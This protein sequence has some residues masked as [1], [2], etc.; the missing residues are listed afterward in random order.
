MTSEPG[1]R[2]PVALRYTLIQLPEAAL[3]AVLL[4][5]AVA[6]GWL[7]PRWVWIALAL[8]LVKDVALYPLYRHAL[9][10][11]PPHGVAALLGERA[12]VATRLCPHGQ[13]RLRGERWRA[14]S[15]DGQPLDPGTEVV[16]V[17]HRGLTLVVAPAAANR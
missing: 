3:V 7:P 6:A 17:A 9:R 5:V 2:L 4:Y 8:W 10:D 16:V 1:R 15:A 13:V 11:A 12:T 14:R